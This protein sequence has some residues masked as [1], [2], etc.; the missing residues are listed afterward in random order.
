MKIHKIA[1]Y[2][3]ACYKMKEIFADFYLFSTTL[4]EK[5]LRKDMLGRNRSPGFNIDHSIPI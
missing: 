1:K 5:N 2:L 4:L 3:Y